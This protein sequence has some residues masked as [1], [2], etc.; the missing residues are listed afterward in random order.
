MEGGPPCPQPA[1]EP[2]S[3]RT[4]RP[5]RPTRPVGTCSARGRGSP[6][7]PERRPGRKAVA[8]AA[9]LP[10]LGTYD[11]VVIGAGAAGMTAALAAA[12]RGL[13]CMSPAT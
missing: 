1:T 7:P 8:S 12:R 10:L 3:H 13:S 11:V 4:T 9:E 2:Y 6:S 5:T